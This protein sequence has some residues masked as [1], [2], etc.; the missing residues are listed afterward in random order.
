[1]KSMLT[2]RHRNN[3][4]GKRPRDMSEIIA[5]ETE[6]ARSRVLHAADD[7]RSDGEEIPEQEEPGPI[8]SQDAI[9]LDE[10]NRL[11]GSLRRKK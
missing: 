1:V 6:L 2:S 11:G 4:T 9:S 8:R 5:A 7:L 10:L 3:R